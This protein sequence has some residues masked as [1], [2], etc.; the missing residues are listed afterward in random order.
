MNEDTLRGTG[1]TLGGQVKETVGDVTGD[2]SLQ[3]SGI[4]DQVK[5]AVQKT[6]GGIAGDGTP[7]VTP[8]IDQTVGKAKQFAKD[9]PWATAALVG[10]VGMAIL[11]TLRGKR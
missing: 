9:R 1:N 5:G 3:T 10:V 6:I 11:N 4:V 7:G 8:K 2:R